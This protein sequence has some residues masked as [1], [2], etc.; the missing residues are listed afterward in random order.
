MQ[1]EVIVFFDGVCNLC[2][3]SVDFLMKIDKN[4]RLKFA[5]LQSDFAKNKLANFSSTLQN[6]DSYL[7]LKDGEIFIEAD[8]VGNTLIQ[9]GGIWKIIGFV[10]QLV[11]KFI[12][13]FFYR[14][15]AK[16]RYK[17]FGKRESC[18]VTMGEKMDFI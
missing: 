16:H 3:G 14:F 18:R 5:S 10:I 9:I 7:L 12:S 17:I 15:I 1:N 4:Q 8:A 6:V 11:P 2:N 13:N